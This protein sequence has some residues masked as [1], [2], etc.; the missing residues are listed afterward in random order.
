VFTIRLDKKR[1]ETMLNTLPREEIPFT[2]ALALTR[3][4]QSSKLTQLD[5]ISRI[6]DRPTRFTLNSLGIKTATKTDLT[7]VVGFKEPGALISLPFGAEGRK[8]HYLI[9]QV[10]GG[11]RPLKGM[12][13]LLRSKGIL[14]PDKYAVPGRNARL[15]SYGN[16]SRGQIVQILSAVKALRDTLQHSGKS[17]R[18]L[19]TKRRNA[20]F[21]AR[22]SEG[23]P[24]GIWSRTS[25]RGPPKVLLAFVRAPS[26]AKRYDFY[27]IGERHAD[28]TLPV[29][30]GKAWEHVMRQRGLI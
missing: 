12:E 4:A 15:D 19:R 5:S 7:A 30:F 26:Y 29:E 8:P 14:P 10:E 6:F 21:V 24:I 13:I 27:G 18:S 2:T 9:P 11:G 22:D 17:Q 1:V 16:M 23:R 25:R 28:A 20:I 3:T